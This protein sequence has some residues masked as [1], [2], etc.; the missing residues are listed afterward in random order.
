MEFSKK[1]CHASQPISY[2]EKSL[3]AWIETDDEANYCNFTITSI[4]SYRGIVKNKES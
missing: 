3:K 1:I 4:D 2:A